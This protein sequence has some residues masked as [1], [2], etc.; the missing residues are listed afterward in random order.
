[1]PAQVEMPMVWLQIRVYLT[2]MQVLTVY[3]S[4][5][6]ALDSGRMWKQEAND[7]PFVIHYL[8]KLGYL[9]DLTAPFHN[10]AFLENFLVRKRCLVQTP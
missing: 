3:Q 6:L 2:F 8:G 5:Y 10:L 1:M 7:H 9:Q 4:Y